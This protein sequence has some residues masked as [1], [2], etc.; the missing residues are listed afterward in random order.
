MTSDKVNELAFEQMDRQDAIIMSV[1]KSMD[2]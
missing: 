1:Q 2:K